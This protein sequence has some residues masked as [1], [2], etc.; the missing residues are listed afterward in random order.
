MNQNI[1]KF[2]GDSLG[3]GVGLWLIGYV[4]GIVLFMAVPAGWIGWV[5]TPVGI[6][7]TTWVLMKKINGSDMFYYLKVAVAWTVIAVLFD[8]V[9]LVMVF[10]PVGGYYKLD[11][12]L[13]YALTF[14]LPL[15]VGIFKTDF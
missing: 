4:L 7:L 15:I 3:W 2:L 9:F 6:L 10:K 8:Y 11:V 12:Y 14:I 13:Y 5:I 1:K